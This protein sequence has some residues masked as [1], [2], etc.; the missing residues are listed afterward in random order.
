MGRICQLEYALSPQEAS[1]SIELSSVE[2]RVAE[3]KKEGE[4]EEE[5]VL[6]KLHNIRYN[7]ASA[8]GSKKKKPL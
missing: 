2:K 3:K 8:V 5:T 4:E 6:T 7:V 1:K